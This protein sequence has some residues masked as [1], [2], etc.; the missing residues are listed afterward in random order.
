MS[1]TAMHPT[2]DNHTRQDEREET[3]QV[4][5]KASP[6]QV[7]DEDRCEVLATLDRVFDEQHRDQQAVLRLQTR[8]WARER[9]IACLCDRMSGTTLLGR[10]YGDMCALP[11]VNPKALR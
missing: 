7:A 9:H 11:L 10:H 5:F 3:E 4:S 6:A 8:I 2:R 1:A